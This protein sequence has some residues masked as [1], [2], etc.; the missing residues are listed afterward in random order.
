MQAGI[1]PHFEKHSKDHG[2]DL[3][4]TNTEIS[5]LDGHYLGWG[6][7]ATFFKAPR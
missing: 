3:N 6:A 2:R 7:E 1:Q 5:T 4:M